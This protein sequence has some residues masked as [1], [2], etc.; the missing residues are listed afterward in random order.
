[1]VMFD[2]EQ[3]LLEYIAPRLEAADYQYGDA[4]RDR[5]ILYG[6]CRNLKGDIQALIFFQR[7]QYE[8]RPVGHG[9]T[10]NLVRCKTKDL[11]QWHRGHYEGFLNQRLR[12]VLWYVY[13]LRLYAYSDH[14]WTPA[15]ENR[16]REELADAIDKVEQYGIPWLEDLNSRIPGMPETLV[17]QFHKELL[18]IVVPDLRELGYQ[19]VECERRCWFC[20]GKQVVE[21]Y[22]AFVAFEVR[23][24]PPRFENPMFDVLLLRRWSKQPWHSLSPGTSFGSLGL[25]L[26]EE[27]GL[28]KGPYRYYDWEYSTREELERQLED[29][30]EKI[31]DIAIPWLENLSS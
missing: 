5:N 1:M 31:K 20:F 14:W 24:S 15:D 13:E 21:D 7:Q 6:F 28:R 17:A 27:C 18:R 23:G 26:W 30:L 3:V 11:T 4:L 25:L 19:E 2:F 29:A 9:F 8:E 16:V 22:S 12:W 10:V